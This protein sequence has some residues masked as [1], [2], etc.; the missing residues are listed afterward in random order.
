MES[1][2]AWRISERITCTFLP[3]CWVYVDMVLGNSLGGKYCASSES[4]L[5][6]PYV[7]LGTEENN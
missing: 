7:L 5:S 4:P 2:A 1:G 3:S 6:I